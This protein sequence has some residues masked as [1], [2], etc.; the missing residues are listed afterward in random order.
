MI[1]PP[2]SPT[3]ALPPTSANLQL[4]LAWCV[5]KCL[6]ELIKRKTLRA[7]GRVVTRAQSAARF[8]FSSPFLFFS[9]LR[10]SFCSF[11]FSYP[12][13]LAWSR[14]ALSSLTC[15]VHDVVHQVC[16]AGRGLVRQQVGE[17]IPGASHREGERERDRT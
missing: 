11:F 13:P 8:L 7:R 15:G 16:E 12:Q 3:R 5:V 9:F 4:G 1:H 6:V 14:D 17:E 10:A 2:P